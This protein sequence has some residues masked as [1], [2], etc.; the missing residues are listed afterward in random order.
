METAREIAFAHR[1]IEVAKGLLE[2]I[3]NALA[4]YEELDIRDSFGRTR[5]MRLGVPTSN[6]GHQ[7]LDVSWYLA[8]PIIRAHIAEKRAKIEALSEIA[9]AEIEGKA[10]R[11]SHNELEPSDG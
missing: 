3:D 1:E 2:E 9:R 7:M 8:R 6:N 4:N 5:G 11:A 10:P